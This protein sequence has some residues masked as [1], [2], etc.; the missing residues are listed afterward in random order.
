M[1]PTNSEVLCWVQ[2]RY[3]MV[4]V[5]LVDTKTNRPDQAETTGQ[6]EDNYCRALQYD[7]DNYIY[8]LCHGKEFS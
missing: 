4:N 3:K 6:W 1:L 5:G 8:D 2:I 7:I